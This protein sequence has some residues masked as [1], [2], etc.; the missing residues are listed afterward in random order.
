MSIVEKNESLEYMKKRVPIATQT[1]FS[2]DHLE[3]PVHDLTNTKPVTEKMND[4]NK[5]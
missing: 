1:Y 2:G 4:H 5:H 3:E